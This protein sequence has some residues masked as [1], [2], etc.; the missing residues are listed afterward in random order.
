MGIS[1]ETFRTK[2][3]TVFKIFW[4]RFRKHFEKIDI[5]EKNL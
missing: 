5:K 2:P 4:I 1:A 3:S